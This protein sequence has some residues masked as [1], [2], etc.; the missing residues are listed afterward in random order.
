M[1]QTEHEI[2]Q[3]EWHY[4]RGFSQAV[5]HIFRA[6]GADN[7][8]YVEDVWKWRVLGDKTKMQLPPTLDSNVIRQICSSF[9]D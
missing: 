7:H 2:M 5:A 4:R 3:Q 6:L 8:E 1:P 9:N